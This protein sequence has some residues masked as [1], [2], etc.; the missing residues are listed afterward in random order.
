MQ[1]SDPSIIELF[2][3]AG[4]SLSSIIEGDGEVGESPVILLVPGQALGKPISVALDLLLEVGNVGLKPLHL[5][6]VDV[7]LD[8]NCGGEPVDDRLVLVGGWIGGGSED[9]LYGGGG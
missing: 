4:E 7:V 9:V 8:P 1:S 2:D 6:S 5:L 3:E